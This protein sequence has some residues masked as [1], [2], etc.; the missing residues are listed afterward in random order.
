MDSTELPGI[1]SNLD[2][3]CDWNGRPEEPVAIKI[4]LDVSK[5]SIRRL[6]P[7][8]CTELI[9]VSNRLWACQAL[10]SLS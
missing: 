9:T 6:H 2:V 10:I 4:T 1:F 3:F 7:P 8:H 5:T